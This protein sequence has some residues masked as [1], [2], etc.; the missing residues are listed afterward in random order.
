M[1]SENDPNSVFPST[2]EAHWVLNSDLISAFDKR[3]LPI[4]H[5]T[6]LVIS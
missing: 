4:L 5:S 6:S 1:T 2:L 3:K